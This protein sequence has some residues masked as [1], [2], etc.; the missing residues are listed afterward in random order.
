MPVIGAGRFIGPGHPIRDGLILWYDSRFKEPDLASGDEWFDIS[1]R[2]QDAAAFGEP[3]TTKNPATGQYGGAQIIKMGHINSGKL[4][5]IAGSNLIFDG[6]QMESGSIN[7]DQRGSGNMDG[8][9]PNRMNGDTIGLSIFGRGGTGE[10][11]VAGMISSVDGISGGVSPFVSGLRGGQF[12]ASA[13]STTDSSTVNTFGVYATAASYNGEAVAVY[14]SATS[15]GTGN[16]YGLKSLDPIY[17]KAKASTSTTNAVLIIED[18]SGDAD[19]EVKYRTASQIV[20]AGGGITSLSAGTG[21]D[22]SST[23]ITL[24]LTEVMANSTTANAVLTSDGDGTLTAET[25]LTYDG[26]TLTVTGDVKPNTSAAKD[27]GSSTLRWNNIYTTDMQLS[28]MDKEEGNEVDGTKGDWTIQEGKDDLFL[29]NRLN[30]KKYR[31]KLEEM[32]DE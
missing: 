29:I 26:S 24:D 7:I 8:T 32:K 30:G 23:T 25:G 6:I 18:T 1:G 10:S 16:T 13:D 19:G 17:I 5:G 11:D 2:G 3:N 22:V 28:N 21:I 20:S 15:T 31:F 27:L 4:G 14:A 12:N 9:F